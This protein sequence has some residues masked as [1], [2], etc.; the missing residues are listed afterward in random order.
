MLVALGIV[1]L[2]SNL[3]YLA[4]TPWE[5]ALRLW[6]LL[7]VAAG[8]DLLLG[9]GSAASPRT[10]FGL[11]VL[12]A[13]V[14]STAT[15][16]SLLLAPQRVI[17]W[18]STGPELVLAGP[19][20]GERF[21]Q[22]L[23]NAQRAEVKL[24]FGAGVLRVGA[25]SEPAALIDGT[26]ALYQGERV[27]RDSHI[28]GDTAYFDMHDEN[29]PLS[30]WD[31][32]GIRDGDRGWDLRLNPEVPTGLRIDTG[33]GM[34]SLDLGQLKVTDLTV[35]TGMG[36]TD[37]TL[38]GSGQLRATVENGIGETNVRIPQGVAARIQVDRGLAS[39]AVAG[40]YQ[41]QGD[42]YVSP[43]YEVARNRVDLTVKGGL[44]KVTIQEY[45][46]Q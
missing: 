45:V 43:G 8:L 40:N 33:V 41:Q 29:V 27:S 30:F 17:G 31:D 38:P 22:P 16:G 13:L 46:L 44:G 10:V 18:T 1:F 32:C 25:Q 14:V 2:L 42:S 39:A 5:T 3:G 23:E 7:I 19:V 21:S 34:A 35:H 6:P 4:W 28:N 26:V 12:V 9:R 11:L 20:S 36:K 24:S 37:L 15:I